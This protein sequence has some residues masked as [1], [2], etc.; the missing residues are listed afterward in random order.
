MDTSTQ[1]C[2]AIHRA[3]TIA[4]INLFF[5]EVRSDKDRTMIAL[6]RIKHQIETL[7]SF[8]IIIE[9]RLDT[10]LIDSRKR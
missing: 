6:G 1:M 7:I 5:T 2:Q 9:H 4:V 3:L 8:A 10:Q